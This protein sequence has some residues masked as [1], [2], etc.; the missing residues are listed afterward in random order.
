MPFGLKNEGMSFQ[1]FMDRVLASLP[2]V[3]V[4]LDDILIYSRTLE[5]H[6][7]HVRTILSLLHG[8][9]LYG[10]LSRCSFIGSP[11]CS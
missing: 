10:K 8:K 9:K 7:A 2:F 4:Y 5:E 6:T 3:L 11:P 1:R